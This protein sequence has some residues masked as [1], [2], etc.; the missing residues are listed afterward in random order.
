MKLGT[1]RTFAPVA[2]RTC[3]TTLMQQP[4]VT[5]RQALSEVAEFKE[6]D[7]RPVKTATQTQK[8]LLD[9]GFSQPE[10]M[11]LVDNVPSWEVAT[12]L[13]DGYNSVMNRL[14][15]LEK[16][17]D[18]RNS[19]LLSQNAKLD[20]IMGR[21]LPPKAGSD[22]AGPKAISDEGSPKAISNEGTPK[23][24][25]VEASPKAAYDEDSPKTGSKAGPKAEDDW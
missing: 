3:K 20:D 5:R 24:V 7:Q 4:R 25:S 17:V 23:A 14:T 6:N 1:R 13:N 12:R 19:L 11:A 8:T 16:T 15:S 21:L 10:T 18:S 22:G 9:S 2:Q